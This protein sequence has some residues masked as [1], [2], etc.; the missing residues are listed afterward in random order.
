MEGNQLE[1][2]EGTRK[3]K[4]SFAELEE[5][6]EKEK[7]EG[8]KLVAKYDKGVFGRIF[9]YLKNH[10]ISFAIGVILTLLNG[11]VYPV[12]SIFLSRIINALFFL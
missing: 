10:K 3:R 1:V 11:L 4:S 8:K 2:P 5:K 9:G 7:E 12:F 6:K